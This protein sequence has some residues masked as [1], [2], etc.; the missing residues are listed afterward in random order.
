MTDRAKTYK[1]ALANSYYWVSYHINA[2]SEDAA[3]QEAREMA[4]TGELADQ[5]KEEFE[6]AQADDRFEPKREEYT[7]KISLVEE[8][9]YDPL[10]EDGARMVDSGGNG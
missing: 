4:A 10:A 5:A 1:T 3:C 7:Y 2:P 6:M 8:A 9:D